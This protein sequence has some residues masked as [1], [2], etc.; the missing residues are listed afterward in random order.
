MSFLLNG[1]NTAALSEVRKH[2]KDPLA[3]DEIHAKL[4][5][6]GGNGGILWDGAPRTKIDD[7]GAGWGVRVEDAIK[8][9]KVKGETFVPVEDF[10]RKDRPISTPNK[11]TPPKTP[12]TPEQLAQRLERIRKRQVY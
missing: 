7:G 6:L 1:L 11:P 9:G 10:R 12:L 8:M 4:P 5:V 2:Y 3:I